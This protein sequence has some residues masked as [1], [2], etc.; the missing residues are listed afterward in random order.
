MTG[1]CRLVDVTDED[2]RAVVLNIIQGIVS[3]ALLLTGFYFSMHEITIGGV[4]KIASCYCLFYIGHLFALKECKEKLQK[5]NE[6]NWFL[7]SL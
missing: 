1:V 6:K 2:H 4:G 7:F 5:L 3:G